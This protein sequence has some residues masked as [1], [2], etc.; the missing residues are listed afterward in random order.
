MQAK[1]Q[2]TE[3][4]MDKV[5][6]RALPSLYSD[7]DNE[8]TP[9]SCMRCGANM[10]HGIGLDGTNCATCK[11]RS[12]TPS[13]HDVSKVRATR[14]SQQIRL[15]QQGAQE[16]AEKLE[17]KNTVLSK[18]L[19]EQLRNLESEFSSWLNNPP[20]K[21]RKDQY[22]NQLVNYSSQ[23]YSMLEKRSVR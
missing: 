3:E 11:R 4:R 22:I 9:I 18:K 12:L 1:V 13:Q 20:D 16:I 17:K 6:S 15:Y 8:L 23:A 2:V 5:E 10:L 7:D 21:D 14:T 19:A